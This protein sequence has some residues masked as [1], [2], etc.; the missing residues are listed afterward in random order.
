MWAGGSGEISHAG[1]QLYMQ[2]IEANKH[3]QLLGQS[4]LLQDY[5]VK[6]FS[7]LTPDCGSL[8]SDRS[9]RSLTTSLHNLVLSFPLSGALSRSF[10]V[11]LQ[12]PT[13][14]TYFVLNLGLCYKM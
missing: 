8:E 9:D 6:S 2:N 10:W 12:Q 11:S 3:G 5:C 1:L 14:G 4:Q 13:A 7:D